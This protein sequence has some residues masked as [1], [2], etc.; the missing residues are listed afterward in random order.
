M[1][2]KPW[3]FFTTD[4]LISAFSEEILNEK[5]KNICDVSNGKTFYSYWINTAEKS[6]WGF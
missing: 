3:T 2:H 4:N 6:F 5:L 1:A